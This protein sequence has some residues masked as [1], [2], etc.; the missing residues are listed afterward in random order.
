MA[1]KNPKIDDL[2]LHTDIDD[3]TVQ[4]DD[5]DPV[6]GDDSDDDVIIID[7]GDVS[8]TEN[9]D[10]TPENEGS[11]YSMGTFVID[12]SS[13]DEVDEDKQILQSSA[14]LKKDTDEE[15]DV[16]IDDADILNDTDPY[17]ESEDFDPDNDG[18]YYD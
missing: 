2:N 9:L 4:D 6:V 11:S 1:K 14:A 16:W 18:G 15:D 17:L 8:E 7:D 13:N 5:L 12:D 10:D 3:S